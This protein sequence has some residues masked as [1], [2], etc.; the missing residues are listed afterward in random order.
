MT[1]AVLIGR[2]FRCAR[3]SKGRSE[4]I[5]STSTWSTARRRLII[6]RI[7]RPDPDRLQLQSPNAH[8]PGEL[9]VGYCPP[10]GPQGGLAAHGNGRNVLFRLGSRVPSVKLELRQDM[11]LHH[12]E[13]LDSQG[14][15]RFLAALVAIVES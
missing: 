14:A 8:R 12:D 4:A 7:P 11:Y 3:S 2:S 13:S 15:R 1:C 9:L 5:A 10:A 6:L